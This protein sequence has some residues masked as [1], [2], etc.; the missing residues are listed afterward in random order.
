MKNQSYLVILPI[1]LALG[2]W[3][4]PKLAAS[5]NG[6]DD[7][8]TKLKEKFSAF[9]KQL[10]TEKV[11]V[12]I[13]S[14]QFEL[15][16]DI[17]FQVYVRNTR[18]M[19]ISE[20]S[21]IAYVELINPK[22]A[23]EVTRRL[24]LKDGT[25]SGDFQLSP[26]W[27][28]GIYKIRSYTNWQKN[29]PEMPF[30]EKE[31]TVQDVVLPRLK[32]K[33]D[34]EKKAYGPGDEVGLKIEVKKLDNK[35]L[36]N[37]AFQ[38]VV[39]LS[40]KEYQRFRTSL[41]NEGK[42]LVIF[43]LP[44]ELTSSDGLVNLLFS[45]E[46][47]TESISRS[48]PIVLN[49]IKL[50]FFPEGGDL[51]H[52]VPARVAFFA[53]NQHGK[54]A[55]IEGQLLDKAGNVVAS[56]TSFHFGMG[57]FSFTPNSQEIYSVKITKPVGIT[58]KYSLPAILPA[59]YSLTA[60][61]ERTEVS[62]KITS[63][64]PETLRIV[65]RQ[66]EKIV[67]S[68]AVPVSNS[69]NIS[70]PTDQLPIGI[71]VITLFDG[72]G[73]ERCERLVFVNSHKQLQ[74]K[75]QPDKP[76]YQPRETV[77]LTIQ[78]L[79]YQGVP[80]PA[81]LSL[82]VVDDNLLSFADDRSGSLLSKMLL[83][84]ELAGKIEEPNFYFD[85][86][87]PKAAQ[88]LDLLMRTRGWRGF[89]WKAIQENPPTISHSRELAEI[90][91]TVFDAYTNKPLADVTIEQ[92]KTPNKAVTGKDGKFTFRNID[93]TENHIFSI[94]SKYAQK[95][96]SYQQDIPYYTSNLALFLYPPH[97]AETP[98]AAAPNR[99]GVG[100]RRRAEINDGFAGGGQDEDDEPTIDGAVEEGINKKDLP[101][102]NA[103]AE[104]K[105]E[106]IPNKGE[107]A[108]PPKIAKPKM[109]KDKEINRDEF[110]EARNGF[111]DE[112]MIIDQRQPAPQQIAYYRARVFPTPIY[113]GKP[114]P[115]VRND[116]RNTIFWK[117]DI[118]TDRRGITTI[119][120]PTS[121]A[122]TS[123]RATIEGF[124]Q[125]GLPAHTETVFSNILPLSM[126]VKIPVEVSMGDEINLP[127]TI[128]NTTK[129]PVTG[130]LSFVVPK[131]FS[132]KS[133]L[134]NKVNVPA[135]SA[136]TIYAAFVVQNIAGKDFME[137]KLQANGLE[138]AFSQNVYI[139]PKGFPQQIS[140][141][142]SDK[143]S[144]FSLSVQQVVPGTMQATL[145]VFP[146][147][148]SS[149]MAGVDAILREP[150]GCFEQ[151]SSSNYPNIIALRYMKENNVTDVPVMTKA[152]DLLDRGYKRLVGFETKQ[153]GYE[154]FGSSP[155]HEALTAY[156]LLEFKDM[157][158]VYA[159]LDKKMV[160]RTAN[161]LLT[162]K[163]NKGGFLR[164]PKALDSFGGASPEITN[165]YIVYALTE[166]GFADKLKNEIES[167][168]SVAEKSDDPYQLALMLNILGQTK[169]ARYSKILEKI[170]PKQS[171][172]GSWTGTSHSITRSGGESLT[173][174]TTALVVLGL[175]KKDQ[176]DALLLDKS[177]KY[178]IGTR[179]NGGM[180]G[181]TQST[182]L[183][184]KALTLYSQYSK[185]TPSSGTVE[186]Y[187][188][189]KNAASYSYKAGERGPIELKGWENAITGN[190]KIQVKFTNTESAL[191]Y[192]ISI[193]YASIQPKQQSECPI[194][195]DVQ[196]AA[197]TVKA[198]ETMRIKVTITNTVAKGQPMTLAIIGIPGGLSAQPWQL[199]EIQEK[200]TVDFYEIRGRELV[201]Y[202]RQMAPNQVREVN[203]DLKADV[204][205]S[206]E[207]PASRSYL[208]YTPE[209]KQWIAG[210]STL[211]SP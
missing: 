103:K 151:T 33:I 5:P 41:D 76:D 16:E 143:E 145:S 173:I 67:Y 14:P 20:E 155:P 42:G 54:P 86:K 162:R 141:S 200:G 192:E 31:I 186:V 19:K 122:I 97:L 95:Y 50:S 87:E 73:I 150:Y 123:F 25:A 51:I 115:E 56:F 37:A 165:I 17:W 108:E 127:I 94:N 179:S 99:G 45:H 83:E 58:E 174:E 153:N 171:I 2:L 176:P 191:P 159:S 209:Q 12:H 157:E 198:G 71:T 32:M 15:G 78:T 13:N 203:L 106:L 144:S 195:L 46:G 120:F 93:L 175:F 210:L 194:K 65:M 188:D 139:H 60:T 154:W 196:A 121:D 55:D 140:F 61:P 84:S 147:A 48:I 7:F 181:S 211:V 114:A 53:Q 75:L 10:P 64:R 28:G 24:V 38:S 187:V 52:N 185:K 79:D 135:N 88:A 125:N 8:L 183:A 206:Y 77:K 90:S 107:A 85:P 92:L 1:V 100:G 205:G 63:P 138:D 29:T 201:L 167:C 34:F 9:F 182:I 190:H 30:F 180:F 119:S 3:W 82:A 136:Q 68:D 44:K 129:N 111:A 177:I 91:G 62:V 47:Q 98:M 208:Y 69:R 21:E 74:V 163:D 146:T 131:A 23:V 105:P 156:G 89:T 18:D 101:K 204:P 168:Y 26:D 160:D 199:K 169:D 172:S 36:E 149:M 134:P 142:S 184:L 132:I 27:P 158:P 11:Y 113:E 137:L 166:A 118:A 70:I 126:S 110:M 57:D 35:P 116:F 112:E 197:K 130:N 148:L 161:W 164:D 102:K 109:E 96:S 189:G 128:K 117:G 202:C 193:K 104:N 72:S 40:G 80:V 39:S 124:S 43:K 22:G 66:H 178:I 6:D 207:G 49:D 133:P 4:F 170:K 152:R 59:G 81:N